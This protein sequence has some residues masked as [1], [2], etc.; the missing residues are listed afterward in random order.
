MGLSGIEITQHNA[1][2]RE[3][4]ENYLEALKKII[5]EMTMKEKGKK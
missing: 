3:I 1:R 5:D 2:F 4:N